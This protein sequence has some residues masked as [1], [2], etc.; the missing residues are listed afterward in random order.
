MNGEGDLASNIT[1]Q[2]TSLI[3]WTC[4]VLMLSFSISFYISVLISVELFLC[5]S[6]LTASD[7]AE[8]VVR[9]LQ[10]ANRTLAAV[11]WKTEP[12]LNRNTKYWNCR[13]Q[14]HYRRLPQDSTYAR[15]QLVLI[16]PLGSI[17]KISSC[18]I[19]LMTSN[20][21]VSCSL[22]MQSVLIH[23]WKI[24]FIRCSFEMAKIS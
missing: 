24:V 22:S 6:I 23:G 7:R 16:L 21:P 14:V 11:F 15:E 3:C 18:E 5:L 20:T 1:L 2:S 12:K 19:L 4:S 10:N 9:F 13:P 17:W 8:T